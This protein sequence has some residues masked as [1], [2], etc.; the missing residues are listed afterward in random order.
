MGFGVVNIFD[1]W[2]SEQQA[3]ALP[4]VKS[5]ILMLDNPLIDSAGRRGRKQ[6]IEIL[7]QVRPELKI[8]KYRYQ[9]GFWKGYR[10]KDA[11]DLLMSG[12]GINLKNIKEA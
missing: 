6:A 12:L 8:Y 5:V 7:R 11:N 9:T 4:D 10:I 3:R 2:L 1:A